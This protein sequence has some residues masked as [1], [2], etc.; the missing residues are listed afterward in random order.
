[1]ARVPFQGH[2]IVVRLAALAARGVSRENLVQVMGNPPLDEDSQL[3]SF[4]PHFGGEACDEYIRRLKG[5][6]LRHVD[7]FFELQWDH[8]EWLGFDAHEKTT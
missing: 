4:G 8:P 1:M 7:D 5:L 3:I 2:G 6:G